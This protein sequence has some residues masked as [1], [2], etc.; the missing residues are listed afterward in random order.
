MYSWKAPSSGEQGVSPAQGSVTHLPC[1]ARC[2]WYFQEVLLTLTTK[3]NRALQPYSPC[4]GGA[5]AFRWWFPVWSPLGILARE[6]ML[7]VTGIQNLVKHT[8]KG[9][10]LWFLPSVSLVCRI[11]KVDC[12]L[13]HVHNPEQGAMMPGE[14]FRSFGG[15]SCFVLWMEEF[16]GDQALCWNPHTACRKEKGNQTWS[17]IDK[18]LSNL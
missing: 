14:I 11:S 10:L 9:T 13:I 7:G 3:G 12:H 17:T 18:N 5:G 6:M 16:P 4:L 1:C 2:C 8:P 15:K